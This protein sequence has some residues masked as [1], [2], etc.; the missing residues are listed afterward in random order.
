MRFDGAEVARCLGVDEL[1]E[2]VWPAGDLEVGRVIRGQLQEPADR[3]AALVELAGRVQEARAVAGRRRAPRPVAQQGPYPGERFVSCRRGRDERRLLRRR[4][5]PAAG[6][7]PGELPGDVAD[8]RGEPQR[9]VAVE[10]QAVPA[11]DRLGRGHSVRRAPVA[12]AA[13]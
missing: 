11:G 9:G 10:G 3:G 7:V 2:R 6:E 13:V 1:A 12:V 5:R 8:A 4:A